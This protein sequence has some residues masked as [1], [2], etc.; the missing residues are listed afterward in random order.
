MCTTPPPA[1][2]TYPCRDRC[3]GHRGHGAP[4]PITEVASPC[5]LYMIVQVVKVVHAG[6]GSRVGPDPM[7][8]RARLL[9]REPVAVLSDNSP[10]W[11]ITH[12]W[13]GGGGRGGQVGR[14][15]RWRLP[16]PWARA[17]CEAC[18][19]PC[20]LW[21]R[22]GGA[23][24]RAPFAA[25]QPVDRSGVLALQPVDGSGVLE[26]VRR[27]LCP[28]ASADGCA[29]VQDANARCVECPAVRTALARECCRG[30]ELAAGVNDCPFQ[31]PV[32][33]AG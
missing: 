17:G 1:S 32:C 9:C 31:P 10:A 24:L 25:L 22:P 23:L 13:G 11:G 5:M 28:C 2:K 6:R 29:P 16:P 8:L 18:G 7:Q 20:V 15:R 21:T 30:L 14:G 12:P 4:V 27:G 26:A 33:A 3:G 19:G